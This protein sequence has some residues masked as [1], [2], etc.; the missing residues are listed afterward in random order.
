MRKILLWSLAVATVLSP[1]SWAADW[2]S[3][4]GDPQRDGW[5]QGENILSKE[6]VDKVKLLYRYK[7]D[8]KALGVNDMT[9]PVVLSRLI[10]YHG[11][12]SLVMTTG[13]N[14]AA[15]AIDA[16]QGLPYFETVF[17]PME[18]VASTP[19]T[20]LCP[21]G[22]TAALV[23]PGSTVVSRF[24]GGGMRTL[25]EYHTISSDGYVRTL[26]AQDGQDQMIPPAKMLPANSDITAP[27]FV[28][29]TSTLYAATINGCGGMGNGLYAGKFTPPE[30]PPFPD[31]PML[32]PSKWEFSSFMT[33][34]SG[35][36]GSGGVSASPKGDLIFGTVPSGKGDVAGTYNDTVLGLDGKSLEVKDWFTPSENLPAVKS[37]IPQVGV[38]PAVYAEGG[39]EYV[40]AGGRDGRIYILDSISLGG[41]DHHTPLY[42]SKPVVAPSTVG[43]GVGIFG[44]FATCVLDNQRWLFVAVH[45]PVTME[46]PGSNGA[47]EHGGILAFKITAD[48]GHP[49]L[50]PAW[51]S[52]DMMAPMAPITGNGLVYALSSGMPTRVAKEDGSPYIASEVEK[53]SKPAVL[54]ILDGAT[55]KELFSSAN[56]GATTF[57]SSGLA[58]ADGRV[59]FTTHDNELYA[60]GVPEVR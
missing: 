36:A 16:D 23:F 27:N 55:G 12:E 11:F 38:T 10:G 47:T 4:G 51:S 21:G 25:G 9:T 8:N 41:S 57:A 45:G 32:K 31:Q 59:Y 60:Y 28:Q 43:D 30:L 35:L 34:G 49:A 56:G 5:S 50:T 15:Y 33:N 17:K 14:G 39:K 13:S 29:A 37:N 18:H 53:M 20:T 19:P 6:D 44:T 1:V 46:F 7:Y 24:G 26:R 3:T 54:Y 52:V 58:L 22:Q 42:A 48:H 2:P 40:I